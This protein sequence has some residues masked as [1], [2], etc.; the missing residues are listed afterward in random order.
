MMKNHIPTDEH[1]VHTFQTTR[2][3]HRFDMLYQR[4]LGKVYQTCLSFTNDTQTAQDY[5]QDI[6]L[7]VF[8][9]LD[10][11]EHQSSFST[12]LYTISQNYCRDQH[13][14]RKRLPTE[15]LGPDLVQ[16]LGG[17]SF[18]TDEAEEDQL[19]LLER[20]LAKLPPL[21]GDLL[22]LKYLQGLSIVA[23][24]HRYQ[25]SESAVKMRLKRSRDRLRSLCVV[26]G[27]E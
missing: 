3:T 7:K 13:R 24:S 10:S 8:G 2:S 25:L 20:Q 4:Y 15:P 22:R 26:E 5:A 17:G 11:F 19:W 23:L 14:Q 6:F 27:D 9:K 21:D 12:W 1:L 16:T 18:F